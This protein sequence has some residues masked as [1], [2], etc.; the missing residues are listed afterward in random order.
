MIVRCFYANFEKIVH[1]LQE[2]IVW[3]EF[4]IVPFIIEDNLKIFCYR[5]LKEWNNE[6]QSTEENIGMNTFK[7]TR[8]EDL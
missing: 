3:G 1:L 4:N 2:R 8:Q 6:T 5:G 7:D